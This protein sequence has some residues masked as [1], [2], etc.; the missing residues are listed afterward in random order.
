M[1]QEKLSH[2]SSEKYV[3]PKK[4]AGLSFDKLILRDA[5]VGAKGMKTRQITKEGGEAVCLR[6][7]SK[8]KPLHAPFG[9]SSFQESSP[10]KTLDVDLTDEDA[11]EWEKLDSW[12]KGKAGSGNY[13]SCVVRKDGYPPRL[14][15]KATVEG[16][17]KTRFWD[18]AGKALDSTPDLKGGAVVVS[19][20]VGCLWSMSGKH[21]IS[22]TADD[23]QVL[24]RSEP[25]AAVCPFE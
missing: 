5:T 18:E 3:F 15:I 19:V 21:G 24:P 9:L 8:A 11:A 7:G 6:I 1:F 23:V 10:K 12:A 17:R 22:L 16:E 20:R 4:M 25:S 13:C 2:P 14:R